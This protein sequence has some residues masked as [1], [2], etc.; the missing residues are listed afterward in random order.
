M[1]DSG[2]LE[3]PA[4]AAGVS[5]S[6]I[7]A[8]VASCPC[9]IW[10][11]SDTPGIASQNDTNAVEVGVKFRADA[12]GYITGLRFYKGAA[13]TGTHVGH[14]W[15]NGG[16]PLATAAFSAETASGWQE[17]ALP[18]PVAITAGTIYVA[19]YQTPRR[20]YS[21]ESGVFRRRP[22][23]TTGCFTRCRTA[24]MA[25]TA[26]TATARAAPFPPIRSDPRT[27]GWTSSST[28]RLAAG[29]TTPPVISNI[30]A[31]PIDATSGFTAWTTDEVS[32]SQVAYGLSPASLT[33]SIAQ[34]QNVTSHAVSLTGLAPDTTYYY[35]VT[36]TDGSANT[37]TAPAVPASFILSS[38]AFVDTTVAD[39]SAGT[40]D[41]A[42]YLGETGN[43]ELMLLPTVAAEF[44]GTTLP[45]GWW[46][47]PSGR[48]VGPR[49]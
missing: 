41:A 22:D 31:T 49:R 11:P 13:N 17:V 28:A 48:R 44:S 2:N 20:R 4:A 40:R 43:G 27:I 9:T 30:T 33:G 34:S 42:A 36:S 32:D 18:S 29:D 21:A 12:D 45:A 3:T 25:R 47:L 38:A 46:S 16:A 35:R 37:S 26:C 5:G 14:L 1:D 8:T 39:F 24:S 10:K 15:T 6:V 23:T 19:S 7:A